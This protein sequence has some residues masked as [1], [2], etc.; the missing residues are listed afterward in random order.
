MTFYERTVELRNQAKAKAVNSRGL[1]K[2]FWQRAFIGFC[3]RL[4]KMTFEEAER[5]VEE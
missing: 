3:M 5:E 1:T 2:T 4:E